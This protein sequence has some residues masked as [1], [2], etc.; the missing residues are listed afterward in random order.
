[1]S[2]SHGPIKT[3]DVSEACHEMRLVTYMR[4]VTG[5][6]RHLLTFALIRMIKIARIR[7]QEEHMYVHVFILIPCIYTYTPYTP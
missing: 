6:L 4:H 5:C 7:I 3:C 1:M 2:S